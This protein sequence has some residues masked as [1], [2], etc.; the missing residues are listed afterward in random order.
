MRPLIHEVIANRDVDD[1]GDGRFSP[2]PS[3]TCTV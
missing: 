1:F 2:H 3:S